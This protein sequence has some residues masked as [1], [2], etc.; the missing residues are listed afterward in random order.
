MLQLGFVINSV[1]DPHKFSCG[2]GSRIPKMSIW[3]RIQ[4][5][6]FSSDPDPK[7]V[8]IK[9]DNL[10]QQNSTT[11]FK[12][13][14]KDPYFMFPVLYSP[15]EPVYFLGFFTSWIRIRI[16]PCGSGSRRLTVTAIKLVASMRKCVICFLFVK[17]I[18]KPTFNVIFAYFTH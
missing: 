1:S 6:N 17:S 13:L 14:Q 12:V 10:Y 2:S 4:T 8:K 7:G 11:F 16:C 9:E 18:P 5:P 15:E 3:L